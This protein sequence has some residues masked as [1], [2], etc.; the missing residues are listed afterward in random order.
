MGE[1]LRRA[2]WLAAML[3]TGGGVFL[4]LA[5]TPGT[6]VYWGLTW[7]IFNGLSLAIRVPGTG[8][9]TRILILGLNLVLIAGWQLKSG[10]PSATS[11]PLLLFLPVLVPLYREQRQE[12]LA[13]LVGGLILGGYSTLKGNLADPSSW[14]ILGGWVAIAGFFYYLMLGLVAKAR[15]AASLQVEVEY[16]RHEYQKACERLAAMEMAAI[17]DDLTGTYNYRYFEQAFSNLLNSRQQPRTLAVLMLDI[18]YFKEINDA[19]GH[20]TGN[21]VLAELATILKKCTREQDIVTRF[22]GEEFAIIL[23]DTDYHGALQLAER[24]R[25]AIAGHT[26]QVEGTAIHITVSAGVAVWP[27]DG[28][29]KNDIIARAD[30]AL[31][32]AKITGRNSVC[33]YQFLKTERGVHE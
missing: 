17:T 20:L 27:V 7:S 24:I 14:A 25:Q 10:W 18:D 32:Q 5:T 28:E 9:I 19:Y 4:S 21:R 12:I 33:A 31:Y 1:K 23:P 26:F 30:R 3:V 6:A 2:D 11:L 16:T 22:G 15:Q 8:F 13:G 29:D